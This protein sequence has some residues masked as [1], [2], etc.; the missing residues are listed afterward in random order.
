MRNFILLAFVFIEG[1]VNAQLKEYKKLEELYSAAQFEKCI[2]QALKNNK[3]EPSELM[4]VVYLSKSYFDLYKAANEKDKL[5]HLK[6]SLKY[7]GKI[8][9]LDKKQLSIE[10]YESFMNELHQAG[11]DY[12]NMIYLGQEKEK[13]KPVF[14]YLARIYND[15][16]AQYYAFHPD[17]V[18]IKTN[19]AGVNTI[20]EKLNQTDKNGL[21][22]GQWKKV[23]PNGVLAYEVFFKD[24]KPVGEMKRYHENG[25]LM[26]VLNYDDKGE[27][28]D[29]KHYDES[30]HLI[31][32]GKYHG[33]IRNG[34]WVYYMDGV[35]RADENYVE[36]KK[37]GASKTY[38]KNGKIAEEKNWEN[39]I[40]NGVW[41]QY[42][43]SGSVKLESRIDKGIRNSV[44]YSYYEN[45]KIEIKG[46]YKNDRMDGD[47]IYYD[48][49]G[50]E[51][52]KI[53]YI[54]GKTDQQK[55]LDEK[56]NE[57][58]KKLDENKNRLIDPADFMNNPTEYLQKN[59]LK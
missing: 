35:K 34:I 14:D 7:A 2:E 49:Q 41:R 20:N 58:F 51:I 26:A 19:I 27:W 17:E 42:Y 39:D 47:W 5:N 52:Q 31:A 10:K 24:D 43:P 28:A 37:T 22:Q 9:T 50:K 16:T 45:G 3:S 11:L 53:K 12:G 6:N 30:A 18:K 25:K 40:E 57:I 29:A 1:L 23:Y 38:Y 55:Q 54:E 8:K 48:E 15:T 21:K 59:G 13:S 44:Y 46:K 36:G 4:P 32:E 56:E 33:K